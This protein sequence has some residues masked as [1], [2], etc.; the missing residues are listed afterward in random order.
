MAIVDVNVGTLQ[1]S[2]YIAYGTW[3]YS[4]NAQL[5]DLTGGVPA[6]PPSFR[7]A[8]AVPTEITDFGVM[9]EFKGY[10]GWTAPVKAADNESLACNGGWH[11]QL[12]LL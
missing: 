9:G 2:G 6:S 3:T 7:V 1:Y 8:F 11:L 5:V 10:C 12:G 4:N